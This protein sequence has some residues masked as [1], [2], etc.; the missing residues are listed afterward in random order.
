MKDYITELFFSRTR[1]T[2]KWTPLNGA[3]RTVWS[4]PRVPTEKS[5]CGTRRKVSFN[6]KIHHP[7][8]LPSFCHHACYAVEACFSIDVFVKNKLYF[9]IMFYLVVFVFVLWLR[10]P[11]MVFVKRVCYVIFSHC[12]CGVKNQKSNWFLLDS[13]SGIHAH[14]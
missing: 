10:L 7:I 9:Y 8:R 12:I 13:W 1:M 3:Q 6:R 4:L 2:G 11:V 14:S 5:S